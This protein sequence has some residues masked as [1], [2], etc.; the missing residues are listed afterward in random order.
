M[1]KLNFRQLKTNAGN[2][3]F[4]IFLGFLPISF[5]SGILFEKYKIFPYKQIKL[6]ITKNKPH[7]QIVLDSHEEISS[8]VLLNPKVFLI[9]G[10]SNSANYSQ[11]GYKNSKNI[12]M[13]LDGKLYKYKDP[14]I[15]AGGDSGAVWG[16]VGDGLI[17]DMKYDSVVIA[18]VG[19][20][21]AS[22]QELV[23]GSN[24]EFFRYQLNQLIK[25]FG[26]I[27]G[28]LFQQG[29]TNHYRNVG[30][31]NYLKDFAQFIKKIRLITNSPIYLSQTSICQNESDKKL[32]TIQNEIIK[33]FQNVLR[34]PN[35]DLLYDRKYRLPDKCHFSLKGLDELSKL[36]VEA[37]K[38]SSEK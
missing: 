26:K 10:Q 7:R 35:T 2:A 28:I 8:S 30:S 4:I 29:E 17:K 5:A 11:I 21:G 20:G 19:V 1:I 16:K 37:I 6:L 15:G 13:F 23:Y 12:F 25:V 22:L 24:F 33:N 3:L 31:E 9:Y 38:N 36:W 32:L 34:G 18:S 27:D 14:V